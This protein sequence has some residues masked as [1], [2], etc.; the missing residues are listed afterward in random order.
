MNAGTEDGDGARLALMRFSAGGVAFCAD[1]DQIESVAVFDGTVSDEL[2]WLRDEL[3]CNG[4][5]D[6]GAPVVFTVKTGT[7]LPYQVVVDRMEGI[8]EV[9]GKEIR[10]FPPL[11]EPFALKKGL[12]GVVFPGGRRALL[13]DFLLLAREKTT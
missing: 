1:T 9:T 8:C 7:G 12:W 11:V 3:G 6:G 5:P 13:I 2:V 10:P 4:S